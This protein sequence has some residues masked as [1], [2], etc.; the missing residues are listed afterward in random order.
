M[1]RRLLVAGLTGA[2]FLPRRA[3][4]APPYPLFYTDAAPF[5]AALAAAKDEPLQ[6]HVTGLT[7]PHHLLAADLIAQA[8]RLASRGKYRRLVVISPDH[9][10]RGK[11]PFSTTRRSFTTPL[12]AVAADVAAARSLISS[13]PLV[14]ESALFSHEH[15]VQAVLPFAAHFFHGVPVLAI[16]CGIRTGITE[17]RALAAALEPLLDDDTLL[18][19]STDFSHYLSAGEAA[20]RDTETL[21]VLSPAI[22]RASPT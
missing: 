21:R 20:R 17:W 19:Q 10:K 4:A 16:V 14:S 22:H 2:A 3:D 6:Q 13:C 7:V 8:L 11:T 18:I 5:K 9:F 15:G 12:G 1:R